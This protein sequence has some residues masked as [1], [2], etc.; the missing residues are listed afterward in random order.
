MTLN[1]STPAAAPP[2]GRGYRAVF[3]VREFRAVFAAHVLSLQGTVVAEIALSVLVF[4]LTGSPLLTALTFAVGFVPYAVSGTLLAGVADRFPP[5]RVLVVCDLLCAVCA[6][7]M[8]LPGTPI[9]VLLGLRCVMAMIAPVFTG[10]RAASLADILPGDTFV[11]GRSLIR[12]VAQGAQIVGFGVG[13]FL[14]VLVSPRAALTITMAAFLGSALLLR[15]GTRRRPA[16]GGG[17]KRTEGGSGR[18]LRDRRVR[19]LLLLGWIQPLF[20]VVPEALAA[21]YTDSIGAGTPGLGFFM[22]AM[23]VGTVLGEFLAGAFLGPAA[24][25]RITVPLAACSL[26]PYALFALRPSLPLGVAAMFTTGLTAAYTLG[27]DQWF[28]AAVPEGSRGRAMTLQSAGLMTIQGLGMAAAGAAAEF[29][30][31]HVVSAVAGAVGTVCVC[32]VLARVRGAGAGR[33]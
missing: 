27:L 17:G 6:A 9:A 19:S 24:R 14:L 20:V 13:G 10:T 25:A 21:P 30:A 12:M 28:V 7:G 18:L 26:L 31:P 2:A 3:A 16:R 33:V 4:R 5:R 8:V 22:A 11:L 1:T 23:P 15:L 29:A 32:V